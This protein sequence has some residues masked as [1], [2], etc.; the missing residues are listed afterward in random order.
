MDFKFEIGKT[1]TYAFVF[2]KNWLKLACV[3]CSQTVPVENKLR[4]GRLCTCSRGD[5]GQCSTWRRAVKIGALAVLHALLW[6]RSGIHLRFQYGLQTCA[7]SKHK[8]QTLGICNRDSWQEVTISK[9]E[10]CQHTICVFFHNHGIMHR[11][12]VYR[13]KTV[14][15]E[16]Y[17]N[18][19]RRLI[20]KRPE[21][22][23]A[24]SH[25]RTML[26]DKK[27]GGRLLVTH[28]TIYWCFQQ[29]VGAL[30]KVLYNRPNKPFPSI[31]I[32]I[33]L[34]SIFFTYDI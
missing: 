4:T 14:N 5:V 22:D 16:L 21:H 34:N 8:I 33:F 10:A 1:G 30:P 3:E 25:S 26:Y 17:C 19:I 13:V 7:E 29:Q 24:P 18:V 32:I 28:P 27:P 2:L 12:S 9:D 31:I 23:N 15:A 11:E 6:P 20:V